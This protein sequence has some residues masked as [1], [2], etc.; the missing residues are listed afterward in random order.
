MGRLTVGAAGAAAL[1]ALAALTACSS[2]S[3]VRDD[4][5]GE[6]TEGGS[7]DV[8]TVHVGDCF[9]D[10]SE[11][12]VSELPLVPCSEPH[13]NEVFYEFDLPDGDY[14]GDT[15]IETATTTECDPVFATFIGTAYED[16]ELAYSWLSPTEESWDQVG[17]RAV[18]CVVYDPS[19]QTTGTLKGSAR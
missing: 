15:A 7:A 19:G 3:P 6:V 12:E 10:T 13:D 16:S 17:D 9:N 11:S 14:P 18:Q 2:S 1:I 5:T 4:D 8:F